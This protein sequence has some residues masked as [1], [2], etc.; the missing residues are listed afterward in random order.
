M[1]NVTKDDT[2][3]AEEPVAGWTAQS[4]E[5]LEPEVFEPPQMVLEEM[6]P[7]GA[8]EGYLLT[9]DKTLIDPPGS[10]ALNREIDDESPH[11]TGY[12]GME[13]PT[14]ADANAEEEQTLDEMTK[15][16]L[17]EYAEG[18][19]YEGITTSMSKDEMLAAIEEAGG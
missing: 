3:E 6:V 16:E 1:A 4:E 7:E 9:D 19:G 5:A 15:A 17:Q 10:I 8:P 12:A 11:L 14:P 18:R 13:A 2:A